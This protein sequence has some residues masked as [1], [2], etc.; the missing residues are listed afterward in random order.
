VDGVTFERI[1]TA[2]LED[3]LIRLGE[4][5]RAKT[6]QCQPVRRFRGSIATATKEAPRRVNHEQPA[7]PRILRAGMPP[8]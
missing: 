2:G 4:E 8:T 1:E 6:Y 3:W 5:L 7:I